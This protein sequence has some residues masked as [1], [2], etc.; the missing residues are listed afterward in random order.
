[1]RSRME[2]S[3]V[4]R[5]RVAVVLSEM[6][7]LRKSQE[8]RL[9]LDNARLQMEQKRNDIGGQWMEDSQR[10]RRGRASRQVSGAERGVVVTCRLL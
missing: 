1:M 10:V 6:E 4:C 7:Y 3:L 2:A 9:V 8:T 5:K